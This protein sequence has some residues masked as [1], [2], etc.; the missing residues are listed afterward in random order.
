MHLC[1]PVSTPGSPGFLCLGP[2]A[3]HAIRVCFAL[4]HDLSSY[5]SRSALTHSIVLGNGYLAL[6]FPNW[7]WDNDYDTVESTPPE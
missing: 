1:I 3:A 4:N 7:I 5:R 6:K 2:D